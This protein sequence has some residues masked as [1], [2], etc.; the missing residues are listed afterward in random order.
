ML[1][2]IAILYNNE[3]LNQLTKK[4]HESRICELSCYSLCKHVYSSCNFTRQGLVRIQLGTLILSQLPPKA[5]NYEFP[6]TCLST[7]FPW[8]AALLC[9]YFVANRRI[10]IYTVLN[11]I[12]N[13]DIV[14]HQSMTSSYNSHS[15][16]HRSETLLHFLFGC[17]HRQN[18]RAAAT[19]S[20]CALVEHPF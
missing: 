14:I 18:I 15:D 8:C 12:D 10:H 7:Y 17:R 5:K 3:P 9:A 19:I 6:K 4:Q 2:P 1:Y 16:A 13:S 20:L 11:A